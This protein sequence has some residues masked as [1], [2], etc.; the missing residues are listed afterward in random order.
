[1][2]NKFMANNEVFFIVLSLLK[3][4]YIKKVKPLV[5]KTYF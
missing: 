1:M 3:N 4:K 2:T 5:I